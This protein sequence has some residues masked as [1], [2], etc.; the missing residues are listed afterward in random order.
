MRDRTPL[1]VVLAAGVLLL[2]TAALPP[3]SRLNRATDRP[4]SPPSPMYNLISQDTSM[5][6]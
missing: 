6:P 1:P 2:T 5:T 3:G 4:R